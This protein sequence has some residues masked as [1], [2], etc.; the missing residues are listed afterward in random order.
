MNKKN[1]F[2]IHFRLV[3]L[4]LTQ[5]TFPFNQ[6]LIP[7]ENSI[8]LKKNNLIEKTYK[9]QSFYIEFQYKRQIDFHLKCHPIY[10]NV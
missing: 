7:N 4:L 3:W 1:E 5:T 2:S 10:Q 9:Y 6:I 8:Q